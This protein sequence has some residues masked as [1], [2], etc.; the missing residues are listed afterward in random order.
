MP[1]IALLVE[2]AVRL[3]DAARLR[4]APFLKESFLDAYTTGLISAID[5]SRRI[6]A[7]TDA[8]RQ[9][10]A[11]SV[12][13]IVAS[14]VQA[15]ARKGTFHASYMLPVE[16]TDEAIRTTCAFVDLRRRA[17]SLASLLML[18]GWSSSAG[19]GLPVPGAFSLPVEKPSQAGEDLFGA[20]CAYMNNTPSVVND[21]LRLGGHTK[22]VQSRDT[23]EAIDAYFRK[24][25]DRLR[26]FVSLPLRVPEATNGDRRV[27]GVLN[28]QSST[29]YVLGFWDGNRRKLLATLVPFTHVLSCILQGV[30]AVGGENV[31]FPVVSKE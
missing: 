21:T 20:P 6:A 15:S 30:G 4:G 31:S 9:R 7:L 23:R 5:V 24:H 12:L 11:T 13:T 27:L 26:S 22:N 19:E 10:A 3:W 1:D 16:P 8:E 28:I 17:D 18:G 2:V 14:V 29:T 25:G